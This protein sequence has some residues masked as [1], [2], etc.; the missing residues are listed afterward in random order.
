[1]TKLS[2]FAAASVF[3]LASTTAFAAGGPAGFQENAGPAAPGGFG[4]PAGANATTV[5]QVIQNGYDDQKVTLTGRMTNFIGHES[6]E[7]TDD[8]GRILIK[9]DDDRNWSHIKKDQLI[10]IYG[11]VDRENNNIE[12]DVK[13]AMPAAK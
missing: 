9:L 11:E 2:V 10:T 13:E 5:Q 6:Y 1:M 7:F 12:I 4:A 8:T 3:A